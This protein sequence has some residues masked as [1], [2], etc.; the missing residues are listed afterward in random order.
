MTSPRIDPS[1][2][3]ELI[4]AGETDLFELKRQWWDLESKLGKGHLAR[5]VLAMANAI[6]PSESGLIVVG[7]EDKK[8]GGGVVG[9]SEAPSQ[10]TV[11][12]LLD[13]Y[14][15]PVPRVRLDEVP[16][17]GKRLSVLEVIWSEFHPHYATRDVDTILSTDAV[18]TRRAGT[19]GRLKPAEI[20]RLI[21]AKEARLGKITEPSPLTVG[22]VELPALPSS[23]D[24]I[25]V[26][27]VNVT[28]EPVTNIN[29]SIDIILTHYSYA[30][31]RRPLIAN[32]TLGPGETREFDC[33]TSEASF[34]DDQG[35]AWEYKGRIWSSWFDLRLHLT[36]R[37]RDGILAEIVRQASL[38]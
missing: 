34:Y 11:A 5:D 26:R 12:Q 35:R 23:A 2:L 21:R 16:Y 17:L 9:V 38:G 22:F 28:E 15:N 7:V 19:V 14:T 30:V 33:R 18:Y 8:A 25:S 6:S 37:G 36:Y 13:T 29:A 20:E 1:R 24:R 4:D 27:V 10:E 32:L 3:G 31:Y